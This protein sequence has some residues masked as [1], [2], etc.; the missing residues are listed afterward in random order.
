MLGGTVARE[1]DFVAFAHA[2][3]PGL[4][5]R[6]RLLSGDNALAEDL[7]QATLLKFFLAWGRS[8]QWASPVAYAHRVLYTSFCAWRGRRWSREFATAQLPDFPDVSASERDGNDRLHQALLELPR[9]QRAVLVARFYDDISVEEVAS[10]LGCSPGT[11]KSQTAR[12]LD[13][14]R[15]ALAEP[16]HTGDPL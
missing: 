10:L 2:A 1:D 13:K 4:L 7:V 15:A 5:R 6:A 14:L 9:K 11:V 3:G 16:S 8:P 12:G